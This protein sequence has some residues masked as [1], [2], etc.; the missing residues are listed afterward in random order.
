[1]KRKPR[2]YSATKNRSYLTVQ[3]IEH[4][5]GLLLLLLNHNFE[6]LVQR[7]KARRK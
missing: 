5:F 7:T 4:R 3:E 1:M 2:A 6:T